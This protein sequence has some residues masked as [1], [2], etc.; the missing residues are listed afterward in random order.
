M[1][2]ASLAA[3]L[4]SAFLAMLGKQWLNRYASTD[5]RG[6]AIEHSQNRQRK[7]NGIVTWYF[8][9]VMESL[10]L[11]L[12]IALLLL[13]CALSNYLWEIDVTTASV[14]LGVTSFGA[15]SY[16][17]VVVAGTAS[18]SCPYQ[19]P[20]ARILR[21]TAEVLYG[22]LRVI[23]VFIEN[24]HSYRLAAACLDWNECHWVLGIIGII[25]ALLI[26]SFIDASHLGRTI[27]RMVAAFARR[28]YV[29]LLCA[30]STPSTPRTTLDLH[31]ISWILQTSL[32]KDVHL[33]TLE[34]LATV[35]ALADFNPTLVIDCFNILTGCVKVVNN[36]VVVTQGLEQLAIAS[37]LC[38]LR[39]FSYLSVIDPMSGILVDIRHRYR[40]VFP[41]W[42]NFEGLPFFHT[43]GSIHNLFYP[44]YGN[45]W[46][47]WDDYKPS[48]HEHL[49][50]TDALTGLAQFEYRRRE[51][52]KQVPHWILHFA[53]HT[54]SQDLLPPT[55]T[56][57]GCLS[58]IAVDLD[59]D[60]SNARIVTLDERY[61]RILT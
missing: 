12:Q 34:Y 54:L 45:L 18:V 7:L 2:Y 49:I 6:S 52:R 40:R 38:L 37:A 27:A 33:S 22:I 30:L 47:G 23:F 29:R 61:D 8:D 35:L 42:I 58:I 11:M 44:D 4:F 59:C 24:S 50:V 26:G 3:S 5:M 36:H 41:P 28:V 51:R 9:H 10:P 19:T 48:S 46:F 56:V 57:I 17:F 20:G 31:C 14:V 53:L 15:L 1:L 13:G 32:D 43:L 25:P 21:Y 39:T 55:P 60:V 16:L